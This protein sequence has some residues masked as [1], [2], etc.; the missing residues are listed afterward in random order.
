MADFETELVGHLFA[1]DCC[2]ERPDIFG[3]I[4]TAVNIIELFLLAIDDG[5]TYVLLLILFVIIIQRAT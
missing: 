5:V 2:L 4:C 1:N 3:S